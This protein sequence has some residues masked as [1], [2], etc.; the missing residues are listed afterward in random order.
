MI[1]TWVTGGW[2][3]LDDG[4]N[5][6][7]ESTVYELMDSQDGATVGTYLL[8]LCEPLSDTTMAA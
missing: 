4:A 2:S 3:G 8:V 5:F 7:K 1:G 6:I